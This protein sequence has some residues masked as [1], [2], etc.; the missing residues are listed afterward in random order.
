[1]QLDLKGAL[2]HGLISIIFTL[3]MVDLFDN[4]G[5]LIGLTRKCGF[6]RPD[7]EIKNLD[8]AFI[9]D[10]VGT[11]FS[12]VVGTTTAT[13][14]LES[15][16]GVAAGGRTGLTAVVTALCFV[17]A[18]FFIPLVGIVPSY[19]T[20]PVLVIVGALMMQEVVNIRFD[21]LEVAI[22]AFL[23]IVVM[24]FTFNIATGFG[25]GFISYALLHVLTGRWREVTLFMYLIAGCFVINF[26]MRA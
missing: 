6:M 24:P 8:K 19:A 12:A 15:A 21:R 10:S 7:G 23:T 16:A 18:L 20:S 26:V 14:Y 5:V 22:P 17:L 9:T 11:M 3:T 13:S 2:S 25:F 4:M 1:M